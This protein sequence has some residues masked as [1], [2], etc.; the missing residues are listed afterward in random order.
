MEAHAESASVTMC[1]NLLVDD[2]SGKAVAS[3]S[4][5]V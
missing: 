1:G 2:C 4:H 5:L 3:G